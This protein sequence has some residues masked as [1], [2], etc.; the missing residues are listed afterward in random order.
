[1]DILAYKLAPPRLGSLVHRPRLTK[2][3]SRV[4]GK[5]LILVT[6]GAGYGKTTLLAQTLTRPDVGSGHSALVWY[7]LDRFDRDM[8]TFMRYLTAGLE[9]AFPGFTKKLREKDVRSSAGVETGAALMPFIQ[10]LESLPDRETF[11]VLDDCHLLGRTTDHSNGFPAMSDVH[12]CLDFLLK[13]LPDHVRLVLISRTEPPLKLSTLRVRRQV[14]E[15]HEPDLTFTPEET[16][17]LFSRIHGRDLTATDLAAL[18]RQTDGWAA[19]LVLFAASLRG[20][21]DQG[22]PPV[23]CIMEAGATRHHI[24]TFLEENLFDTQPEHLKAFMFRTALMD[25]METRVC[26]TILGIDNARD[27]FRQMMGAHL[28]VVPLDSSETA[29]QYH[30]LFRDFLLEKLHT[31]LTSSRIQGLHLK[32]AKVLAAGGNSLALIHF[33]EAAAYDE[34]VQFLEQCEL[35]FLIQGK[36]YFVRTCLEKI[37]K[38]VIADNPRLLFMEAKQ[39]SYFGRP[40]KSIAC[41]KAACRIFRQAGSDTHIAKCLVDIGAQYYYTGHIPEAR[42]LM[43]QVLETARADPGT[44]ILAVTY[45]T[46]FCAVLGDLPHA[47]NHESDARAVISGF[48]EFEQTAAR[49]AIDT[50]AIYIHYISGDFD[51]AM[52]LNLDLVARCKA[53]GLEAF[54]P[55]AYYHAAAT[56]CAL[57]HYHQGLAYA[58]K[59]IHAAEKIHLRDS[60]T[61]WIYMARS[62]N[63]LGLGHLDKAATHAETA[64]EIFRQPGN[65]WGMANALDLRARI[66]LAAG[67]LSSALSRVSRALDTIA[68][69][70]LPRTCAIIAITRARAL[71]AAGSFKQARTCLA[72]TRSSLNPFACYLCVSWL[73]S[74]RCSHVLGEKDTAWKQ[75]QKGL[76]AARKRHLDRVVLSET[77]DLI[78]EMAALTPQS[79]FSP[80]LAR[81]TNRSGLK[82]KGLRIKVLGRFR[83]SAGSRDIAASDWTSSRSLVLFQ[84]LALHRPKGFIP[85]EV[86]VEMLWPDQDPHRTGR[87]FNT[88]MSQLRKIL[89]PDL[90]ARAPSAY[91]HRRKDQYR[92]CLGPGGKLDI[93]T[94]RDLGGQALKMEK[95]DPRVAVALGR[96]AVALY[97]GPLLEEV[98]YQEWCTRLKEEETARFCRIC[99]MLIHLSRD[100]G[101]LSSGILFAEKYLWADPYDESIYQNLIHFLLETGQTGRA[102]AAITACRQ[103]MAELDCPL[104]PSIQTLEKKISAASVQI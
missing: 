37:P 2:K 57:G 73:L 13:R 92:L 24:F 62:E 78:P 36:I 30:P 8:V 60:Q 9:T 5:R 34:A 39:Y 103:R 28:M 79:V 77:G 91:I 14:L 84:Y 89:E 21:G 31:T 7:R 99:R 44:Y 80:Y 45:L 23:P 63:H 69:F 101:D 10:A 96:K 61:G 50:S 11:I 35:E 1:M 47:R 64:L 98:R 3:L 38:P 66:S 81:I 71:M 17:S 42:D 20:T 74:A 29:F 40:D 94:F 55:L 68:G 48:P 85:K 19:G 72:D 104:S 6:A 12:A 26:D 93:E 75:F 102:R 22:L 15:I 58:E 86:L 97:T 87:R 51:K 90:P 95:K 27:C 18:Q 88:A 33:I 4:S 16:A 46:F 76:A 65:R 70:G 41:L 59:G 100:A 52:A 49:A 32:I 53:D 56:E 83:V 67:E 43:A 82:G 25:P 54:L